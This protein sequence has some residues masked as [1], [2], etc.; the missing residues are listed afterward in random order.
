MNRVSAFF[1]KNL[2]GKLINFLKQGITPHKLALAIAI[3]CTVGIFP[4]LGTHTALTLLVI[5]IF[6]L[7]PASVFLITNL[8]FPL[9]FVFVIPFVRFGE[10]IFCVPHIE[11][12]ISGVYEMM[13]N[14]LWFTLQ[15]LGMTLIYAIF[16]WLIF[17]I[18]VSF[19]LYYLSLTSIQKLDRNSTLP[20]KQL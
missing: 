6:R 9:F 12:S 15:K 1:R 19:T 3:G 17:S 18:P 5:F 10:M 4:V 20:E 14:G 13:E 11:I 7:N 16:G 8:I 2:T